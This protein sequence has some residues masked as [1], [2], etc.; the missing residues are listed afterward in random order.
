MS[1]MEE[2]RDRLFDTLENLTKDDKPME[3]DRA[4]AIVDVAQTI[5]NSAKV[6]VDYLKVTGQG[7]TTQSGFFPAGTRM[8]PPANGKPAASPQGQKCRDCEHAQKEVPAVHVL[9]GGTPLCETHFRKR[10]GM[11]ATA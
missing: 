7:Q 4:K 6:E 11:A 9:P 10:A 8:L 3:L 2:L 5:I 1:K